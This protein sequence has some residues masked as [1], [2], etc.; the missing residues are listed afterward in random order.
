MYG[1]FRDSLCNKHRTHI[2]PMEPMHTSE[3]EAILITNQPHK[4][5]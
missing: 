3:K 2:L 4:L 1:D 5:V